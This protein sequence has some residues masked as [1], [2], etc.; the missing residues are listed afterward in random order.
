MMDARRELPVHGAAARGLQ[1]LL[2]GESRRV[3][4]GWSPDLPDRRGRSGGG[5]ATFYPMR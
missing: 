3:P 4:E 1:I 2:A 5:R